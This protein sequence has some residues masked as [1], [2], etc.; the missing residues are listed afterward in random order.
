MAA[1]IAAPGT[2]LVAP[3]V[4]F[5]LHKVVSLFGGGWGYAVPIGIVEGC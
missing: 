4:Q 1:A 3:S 5:A 2:A